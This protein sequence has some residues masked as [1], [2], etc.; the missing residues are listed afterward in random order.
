MCGAERSRDPLVLDG[1][2]ELGDGTS[3]SWHGGGHLWGARSTGLD[4]DKEL[5]NLEELFGRELGELG[6]GGDEGL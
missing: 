2:A 1:S 5:L 6:I 3:I 4:A